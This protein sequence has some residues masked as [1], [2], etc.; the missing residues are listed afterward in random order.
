MNQ[1]P[2]QGTTE[3]RSTRSRLE[4]P[5]HKRARAQNEGN[6][7]GRKRDEAYVA[8]QSAGSADLPNVCAMLSTRVATSWKEPRPRE[9][10]PSHISCVHYDGTDCFYMYICRRAD[11]NAHFVVVRYM[12]QIYRH[13]ACDSCACM[14]HCTSSHTSRLRE[15]PYLLVCV[16]VCVCV[17]ARQHQP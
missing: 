7:I 1:L 10:I 9:R 12:G 2:A 4:R 13:A 5:P 17:C 8:K 14:C 11:E 3:R 6:I 16:C 15:L